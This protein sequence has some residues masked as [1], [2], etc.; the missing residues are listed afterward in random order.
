MKKQ[1][2][3]TAITRK[4]LIDTYFELVRKGEKATVGAICELAGYNRC[5]FYRYFSIVIATFY[6][7]FFIVIATFINTCFYLQR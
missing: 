1:P 6:R 7:Y 4:K 5:T 3:L 2:E